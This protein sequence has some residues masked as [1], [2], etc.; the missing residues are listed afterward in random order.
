MGCNS[1]FN[2][3]RLHAEEFSHIQS[4]P[5]VQPLNGRTFLA[6]A[7]LNMNIDVEE[8]SKAF[9][10]IYTTMSSLRVDDHD[11]K[12]NIPHVKLPTF[13]VQVRDDASSSADDIQ[14]MFDNLPVEDKKIYFIEDTPWR[15]HG[16]TYFSDHPQQIIDWFDAHMN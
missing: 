14:W 1:T 13:L 9:E 10:T 15:F 5:A 3:L 16:Y 6:R 12:R 11:M 2:A 4:L 7:C 8:G